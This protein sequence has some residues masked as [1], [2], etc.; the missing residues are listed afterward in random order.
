MI[1]DIVNSCIDIN[2]SN[3]NKK[4]STREFVVFLIGV[5]SM[6]RESTLNFSNTVYTCIC[7]IKNDNGTKTHFLNC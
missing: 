3:A 6:Q 4:L 5:L 7:H 2:Y 1:C